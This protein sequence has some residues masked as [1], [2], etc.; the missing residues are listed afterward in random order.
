M[1]NNTKSYK[2][3]TVI[4][5]IF[6]FLIMAVMI[7]PFL[8]V[9]AKSFNDGVDAARGGIVLLPRVFTL[10]N[11]KVLFKDTSMI[12]SFVVFVSGASFFSSLRIA[13]AMGVVISN[14]VITNLFTI[15]FCK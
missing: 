14:C 7:F 3:F 10:D 11:Y 5:Y 8:N 12:S 15:C 2:V 9:L 13:S 4:N 1:N 6:M